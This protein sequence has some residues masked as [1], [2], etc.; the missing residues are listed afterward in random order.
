MILILALGGLILRIVVAAK[1]N[2]ECAYHHARRSFLDD[3]A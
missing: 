2:D 1:T 3:N